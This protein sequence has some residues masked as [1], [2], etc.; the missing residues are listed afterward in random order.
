MIIPVLDTY[1]K[2]H[3]FPLPAAGHHTLFYRSAHIIFDPLSLLTLPSIWPRRSVAGT[4][5]ARL[6]GFKEGIDPQEEMS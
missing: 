6:A 5:D 2:T 1:L 4:S 3:S